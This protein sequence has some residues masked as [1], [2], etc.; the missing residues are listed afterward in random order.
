MYTRKHTREQESSSGLRL[1]LRPARGHQPLPL[2]PQ[3]GLSTPSP[4]S[5]PWE[6]GRLP[7]VGCAPGPIPMNTTAFTL[8]MSLEPSALTP[9]GIYTHSCIFVL[10]FK[11]PFS[12]FYFQRK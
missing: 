11:I 3:K 10:L 6:E 1:G 7:R 4:Q 2:A 8:L 9:Y 5:R 12:P